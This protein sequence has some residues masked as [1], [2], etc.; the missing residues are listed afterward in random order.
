MGPNVSAA[1]TV[2]TAAAGIYTG[3]TISQAPG[4]V[5]V[6]DTVADTA[7]Q[8]KKNK[9]LTKEEVDDIRKKGGKIVYRHRTNSSGTKELSFHGREYDRLNDGSLRRTSPKINGK[10][11]KRIRRDQRLLAEDGAEFS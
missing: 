5:G 9:G 6:T 3:E 7:A 8:E 10:E 2:A 1:A 4:V 11:A